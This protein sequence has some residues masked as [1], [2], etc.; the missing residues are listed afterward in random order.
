MLSAGIFNLVSI[1]QH[2]WLWRP[3]RRS[4]ICW[5]RRLTTGNRLQQT[6]V[7]LRLCSDVPTFFTFQ[8]H[9]NRV[10]GGDTARSGGLHAGLCHAFLDSTKIFNKSVNF[11]VRKSMTAVQQNPAVKSSDV[12]PL[13]PLVTSSSAVVDSPSHHP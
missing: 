4:M 9:A 6:T 13:P 1:R 8:L 7:S 10:K 3:D 11:A 12:V 5:R 2:D